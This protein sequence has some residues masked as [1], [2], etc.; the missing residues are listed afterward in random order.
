VD[1]LGG[2]MTFSSHARG[3]SLLVNIFFGASD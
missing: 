2:Q 3:T 1:A